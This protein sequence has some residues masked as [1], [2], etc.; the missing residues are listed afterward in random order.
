MAVAGRL[1]GPEFLRYP[2]PA[3]E[4]EVIRLTDPAFASGMTA[5]HLRQFGRRS[6]TLLYWS[7]R[8][9]A[10]RQAFQLDLKT[11]ASHQLT[12]ASALDPAS[13]ALSVDERSLCYFDG[14]ALQ[15]S[16]LSNLRARELYRIPAGATRTGMTVAPDGSVLFAETQ[17]GRSRILRITRAAATTVLQADE[18]IDFL[19]VRPRYQQLLY[20]TSGALWLVNLDGTGKL[21]LKPEPGQIGEALWTQS[22]GTLL[23]LFI[24]DDPKQL[25]TLRELD[26]AAN[27]DRLIAKTSQF[28]SVAPNADAS[29][30]VGA[31]RSRAS[32]YVL[33][34][35]RVTRRELTLCEHHASDPR[36]V[37]PL[38]SPDS[39]SVFFSSDRHGKSALYRVHIEKFVEETVEG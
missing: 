36:M 17:G 11:G 7:E 9:G 24:P 18:P 5:P 8:Y 15:E 21:R 19:A 2:D 35:L 39:Q 37:S 28:E 32:A 3:T 1:S 4:L 16:P 33:L 31:S 10:A 12:E 20:R 25:I 26:P 27:T 14:P 29:V 34:L 13:L 23:Y 22:G 6:D 38:F 30:F